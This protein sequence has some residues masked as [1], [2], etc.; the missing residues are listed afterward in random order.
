[1]TLVNKIKWLSSV[2]FYDH[3]LYI[4]LCA[5]HPKSNLLLYIWP[6]LPFTTHLPLFLCMF[7]TD[8]SLHIILKAHP[9]CRKWHTDQ[10]NRIESPGVKPHIY[11]QMILTKESKACNWGE[12][13]PHQQMVLGKFES[14]MQKMKLDYSLSPRTKINSK[15]IKDLTVRSETINYTE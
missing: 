2:W 12:K 14:H 9:R 6:L 7:L 13:K 4:L 3:Y 15:W 11:G 10:W 5:H 1:M 8:F